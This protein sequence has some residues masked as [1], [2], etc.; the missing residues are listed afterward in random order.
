MHFGVPV[1]DN[2]KL[3][4][5]ITRVE[6]DEELAAYMRASNVMAIDRLGYSDHGP[7]HIRI[8]SNI[9][10]RLLRMLNDA[11][12]KPSAVENYELS[13]EDAEV[14]VFLAS[15]MHDIGH[16]V[17]R[18]YHENFSI[19]LALPI[20]DRILDGLYT[21]EERT[22]VKSEVLHAIIAHQRGIKPLTL[23]AGIVR[24]ADALDMKKGRARIPFQAGE[25]NIHSVSALAVEDVR[26]A[27]GEEKPIEIRIILSNSSGIFQIDEMLRKKMEG[28]EL[29]RY[30]SVK[31]RVEGEQEKRI[32]PDF[33][34]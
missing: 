18:E 21:I 32:I 17:H 34:L 14:I 19:P 23:E 10:M 30:M 7:T 20:L 12:I 33:E 2:R 25:V 26:I 8:V 16:A 24:V 22:I 3:G 9:A 1:S 5:V 15:A 6:A 29:E 13:Q 4:E 28:T 11:G 27:K 31:V